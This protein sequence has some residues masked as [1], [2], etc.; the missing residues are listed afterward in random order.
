MGHAEQVFQNGRGDAREAHEYGGVAGVVLRDVVDVGSG[1]EKVGVIVEIDAHGERAG[2]GRPMNGNA[3]E[4][5]SPKLEGGGAVRR[6]LLDA[7][8]CKSHLAD[9]VEGDGGL[10]HGAAIILVRSVRDKQSRRQH[11][12]K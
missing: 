6:A 10:W 4:Q 1:G 8:K 2:F 7:G 11:L 12:A 3:G 5:L 9:S